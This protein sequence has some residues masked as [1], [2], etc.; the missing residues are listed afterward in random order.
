MASN[1]NPDLQKER[2][3]ASFNVEEMTN[4]LEDGRQVVRRQTGQCRPKEQET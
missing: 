3:T 1:I 4:L 2:D